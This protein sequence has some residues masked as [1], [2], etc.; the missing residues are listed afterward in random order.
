MNLITG[1]FKTS[2]GKK[3]IM[4]V[5]GGGLF[6]FVIGHMLGNLQIFLGPEH[7]NAYGHFLQHSPE[8]LWPARIGLLAFVVLH[9]WSAIALSRENQAA[10]PVGYR[11]S[12]A[13]VAA[14]Y[15]SRVM[16]MTGLIVA[17]FIIYH[18][19]H[20][21][22]QT[23]AVN[24]TGYDFKHFSDHRARHDVYHMMVVGFSSKLASSFY[25][26]G[27][28]LL[29]LHLNH[30]V[31]AMFQSLGLKNAAYAKLIERFALISSGVIFVGNCSI[32]LAVLAG[33]LK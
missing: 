8:I 3:F 1:L 22:A 27:M 9:I 13:P 21:T 11:N 2:I 16:A 18:L 17:S 25:I 24:F 10:R 12:P 31:N 20:F 33:L 29:C 15:Q 23:E 32:P 4:A 28:A 7:I 14:S 30:G 19:L 6:L 5:T 26:L